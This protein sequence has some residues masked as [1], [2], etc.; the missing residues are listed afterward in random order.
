MEVMRYIEDLK[1][2]LE[3]SSTIPL[4]GKVMVDKDEVNE[5]LNQIESQFPQDLAEAQSI[6][7]RKDEIFE[8]A[9]MQAKQI[10][11][12]AHV[13]A[14]KLVN[15]DEITLAAQEQAREIMNRAEIE[16]DQIRLSARDYVDNMLENTQ[17]HL[18]DMIKTINE[19][20]KEL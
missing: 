10:V 20:R 14:Q 9:N 13:E 4:T 6:R 1:D 8:E 2:L 15:E 7:D 5:L 16:S 3:V 19:N 11:Q 18:S 12:A 17:V